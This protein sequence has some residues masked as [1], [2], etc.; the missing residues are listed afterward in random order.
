ME[1]ENNEPFPWNFIPDGNC[2]PRRIMWNPFILPRVV[3]GEI[4]IRQYKD[5]EGSDNKEAQMKPFENLG[6]LI[7]RSCALGKNFRI[8]LDCNP[9]S[10]HPT[11]IFTFDKACYPEAPAIMELSNLEIHPTKDSAEQASFDRIK[12]LGYGSSF[13][14]QQRQLAKLVCERIKEKISQ[15][16]NMGEINELIRSLSHFEKTGTL[17]DAEVINE[18]A[19]AYINYV[20]KY[21]YSPFSKLSGDATLTIAECVRC[22][23]R[24]NDIMWNMRNQTTFHSETS[25]GAS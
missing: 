10:E 6:E 11:L 23:H 24:L 18:T 9:E 4:R 1:K 7:K 21:M 8:A 14:T 2:D 12:N 13:Y 3:Q 22:I 25:V 19:N 15:K 17:P 5:D 16:A 20:E